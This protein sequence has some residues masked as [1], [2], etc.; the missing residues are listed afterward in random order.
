MLL[1]ASS[2]ILLHS[3]DTTGVGFKC[4]QCS[5]GETLVSGDSYKSETGGQRRAVACRKT[6][7]GELTVRHQVQGSF[8]AGSCPSTSGKSN[9]LLSCF[10]QKEVVCGQGVESAGTCP[11]ALLGP[12]CAA[13]AL[14]PGK[15]PA[16]LSQVGRD[17]P[18]GGGNFILLVTQDSSV[19]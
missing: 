11:V 15:V 4:Q 3:K 6:Q 16:D 17:L 8:L 5:R 9:R 14:P 7:A 10:C 1:I 12:L 13:G 18:G 2:P 19:S